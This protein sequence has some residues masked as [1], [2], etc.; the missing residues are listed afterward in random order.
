MSLHSR[1]EKED[2]MEITPPLRVSI[3]GDS[4]M[5][6]LGLKVMLDAL[7]IQVRSV[8]ERLDTL[9]DCEPERDDALLVD[10]YFAR[11][12][13][14]WREAEKLKNRR[15]GRVVV[16][17]DELARCCD[18]MTFI[19]RNEQ[20]DVM[21][22]MLL[23]SLTRTQK[24]WSGLQSV[25][26]AFGVNISEQESYVLREWIKGVTVTEIAKRCNRSVKTISSHKRNAMK[27]LMVKNDRELYWQLTRERR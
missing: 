12:S 25:S 17:G 10:I 18:G 13:L 11:E 19:R 7:G 8:T 5:G 22:S 24:A 3:V 14:V 6:V 1:H 4:P 20:T 27:K 9:P 26:G 2:V 15:G 16:F 21:K 23:Q